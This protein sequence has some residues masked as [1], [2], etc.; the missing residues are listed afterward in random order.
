LVVPA[1]NPDALAAA[2]V[3]VLTD[4]DLRHRLAQAARAR[5]LQHFTLAQFLAVYREVYPALASKPHKVSSAHEAIAVPSTLST[6]ASTI[7]DDPSASSALEA[8][9]L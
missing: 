4:H 8:N 6:N 3:R 7:L 9:S 2:C 1:R 5:A